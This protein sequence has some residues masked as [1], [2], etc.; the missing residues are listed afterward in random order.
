[1]K[2]MSR[3]RRW[4]VTGVLGVVLSLAASAAVIAPRMSEAFTLIEL[5]AWG[6]GP[7]QILTGELATLGVHNFGDGSVTVK[8][9][10]IDSPSGTV[11]PIT[12]NA[13]QTLSPGTG[14][15]IFF[16]NAAGANTGRR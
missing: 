3:R 13:E 6:F 4:V 7:S 14:G 5:T 2:S 12:G 1:M 8:F 9:T 11:L 15:G 10:I 16:H